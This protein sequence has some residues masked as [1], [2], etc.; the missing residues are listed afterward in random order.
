LGWRFGLNIRLLSSP[1]LPIVQRTIRATFRTANYLDDLA[2][3]PIAD[4]ERSLQVFCSAPSNKRLG[5]CGRP[6]QRNCPGANA[7]CTLRGERERPG[8]RKVRRPDSD[9]ARPQGG[10]RGDGSHHS[11]RKGPTSPGG[12]LVVRMPSIGG[13]ENGAYSSYSRSVESG[14]LPFGPYRPM[15]AGGWSSPDM[16]CASKMLQLQRLESRMF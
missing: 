14:E 1:F 6:P 11:F 16:P 13:A 4:G 15:H 5:Y 3:P 8:N 12:G 9:P 7:N 10:T 2:R